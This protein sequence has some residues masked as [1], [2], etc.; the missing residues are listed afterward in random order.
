MSAGGA[1]GLAATL[2]ALAAASPR[3]FLQGRAGEAELGVFGACLFFGMAGSVVSLGLGQA[4]SAAMARAWRGGDRAALGRMLAVSVA[5][6]AGIGLA[7]LLAAVVLGRPIIHLAFGAEFW[8]GPAL[9][10]VM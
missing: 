1:L 9:L 10:I 8:D 5:I 3:Y 2:N 7:M 4:Q 6:A